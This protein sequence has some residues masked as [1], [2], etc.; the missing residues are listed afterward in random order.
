[1]DNIIKGTI[2]TACY[3]LFGFVTS[4]TDYA[5]SVMLDIYCI[6]YGMKE[7]NVAKS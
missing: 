1:M 2:Q 4:C 6:S 7:H 3:A 5:L